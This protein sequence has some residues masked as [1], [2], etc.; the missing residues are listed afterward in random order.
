MSGTFTYPQAPS[1]TSYFYTRGGQVVP[2]P[3]RSVLAAPED[4]TPPLQTSWH[5]SSHPP[6]PSAP[7][8]VWNTPP[9]PPPSAAWITLPQY[10][11]S[12]SAAN[13]VPGYQIPL[14]SSRSSTTATH[15][16]PWQ[17]PNQVNNFSQAPSPPTVIPDYQREWEDARQNRD[18]M[19]HLAR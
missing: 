1:G 18:P 7:S 16:P 9:V 10:P 8:V 6:P 11:Q 12:A 2:L 19:G 14:P 4:S 5:S 17:T 3:S 15:T 13:Q